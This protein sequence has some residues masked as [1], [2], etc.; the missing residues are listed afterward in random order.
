MK[1]REGSSQ[2]EGQVLKTRRK[3][4]KKACIKEVVSNRNHEIGGRERE[5]VGNIDA[6]TLGMK[7]S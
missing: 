2:K 3:C 1:H 4:S 6:V 7:G 5:L